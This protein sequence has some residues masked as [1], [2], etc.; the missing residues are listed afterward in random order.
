M[1]PSCLLLKKDIRWDKLGSKWGNNVLCLQNKRVSRIIKL[2]CMVDKVPVKQRGNIWLGSDF[3][4]SKNKQCL[5]AAVF[6]SWGKTERIPRNTFTTDMNVI[7]KLGEAMLGYSQGFPFS[8][9]SAT[10]RI[11]FC[12]LCRMYV[13]NNTQT[14]S[15]SLSSPAPC[16][17]GETG[18]TWHLKLYSE[19]SKR[20]PPCEKKP[21]LF[22]TNEKPFVCL[23]FLMTQNL[24]S[25]VLL[26]AV[27]FIILS[28]K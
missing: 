22:P 18:V 26:Q 15:H 19:Q 8:R 23:V 2:A 3:S 24:V 20:D 28:K 1:F 10:T 9:T 13:T 14:R 7:T 17:S 6:I 27:P 12:P 11:Q 25:G 4:N 5:S 16:K 21:L